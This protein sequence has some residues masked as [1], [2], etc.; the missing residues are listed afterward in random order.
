MVIMEVGKKPIEASTMSNIGANSGNSSRCLGV[1]CVI[2][3][4]V[5]IAVSQF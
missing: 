4:P 1:M 2:G 5:V 3:I